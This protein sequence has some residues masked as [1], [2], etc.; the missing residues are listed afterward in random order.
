MF[1][2]ETKAAPARASE[3]RSLTP[4]EIL[5]ENLKLLTD[6]V[7]EGDLLAKEQKNYE[8]AIDCFVDATRISDRIHKH[9]SYKAEI[10]RRIGFYYNQLAKQ[11]ET[12]K[13]LSFAAWFYKKAL[14]HSAT[15]PANLD[16][17]IQKQILAEKV[18]DHFALARIYMAKGKLT[19]AFDYIEHGFRFNNKM[20][21]SN[22][23]V[24]SD[25]AEDAALLT[26]LIECVN[27]LNDQK[28]SLKYYQRAMTIFVMLKMKYPQDESLQDHV[29]DIEFNI[30][31]LQQLPDV[32]P[33]VAFLK[34][35]KTG[36]QSSFGEEKRG[37][38][39]EPKTVE[40]V[41]QELEI[42]VPQSM[43]QQMRQGSFSVGRNSSALFGVSGVSTPSTSPAPSPRSDGNGEF[44][45]PAP[46]PRSDGDA[47]FVSPAPSP[48]SEEVSPV[49]RMKGLSLSGSD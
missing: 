32:E 9:F 28:S 21:P 1:S 27:E 7:A 26:T 29:A 46:S 38:E 16:E 6:K 36:R 25:S 49:T 41:F 30:A 45:S 40:A 34:P 4:E 47:E 37:S 48:R 33:S 43:L 2:T 22:Y 3:S 12:A 35:E 44:V 11:Q 17:K 13:N 10:Y 39:R 18:N 15:F 8:D 24:V 23:P 31:Q 14:N 20:L 19:R 5:K 42:T